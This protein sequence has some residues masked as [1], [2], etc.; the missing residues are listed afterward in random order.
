MNEINANPMESGIKKLVNDFCIDDYY[1]STINKYVLKKNYSYQF[2][3]N[4]SRI[5]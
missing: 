2:E 1:E 4:P 3:K 5:K